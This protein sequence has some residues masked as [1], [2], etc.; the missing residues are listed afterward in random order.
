[1]RFALLRYFNACGADPDGEIGEWHA[2][3]T[4]LVPCALQA[5]AGTIERLEI[6][7]NDYD[8]PDGTCVRDYVH[9]A[10]LAAGHVAAV[11]RLLDAG[12]SVV[13]NLGTGRG[14]SIRQVVSAIE[15]VCG[16]KVA[17]R[18]SPR[19]AGDPPALVADA[20]HAARTLGFSP[21]FSDLD[22]IVRTAAPFFGLTAHA[23]QL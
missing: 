15:R 23:A 2:P 5:A 7:G 11:R 12:D 1:M 3:E 19:R 17:L 20:T 8:T 14:A 6:Y 18:Y 9:V 13:A 21:R 4:H 16:R 22:T 10:D